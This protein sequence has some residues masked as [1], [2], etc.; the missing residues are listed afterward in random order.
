MKP[1]P[2]DSMKTGPFSGRSSSVFRFKWRKADIT[3]NLGYAPCMAA[4]VSHQSAGSLTEIL[5][6][7]SARSLQHLTTEQPGSMARHAMS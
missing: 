5:K 4:P 6:S 3:A 7:L 2:E 1:K